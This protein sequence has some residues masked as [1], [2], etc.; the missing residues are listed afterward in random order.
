LG[1]AGCGVLP[2]GMQMKVSKWMRMIVVMVVDGAIEI[3]R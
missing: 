3:E 1:R 2:F